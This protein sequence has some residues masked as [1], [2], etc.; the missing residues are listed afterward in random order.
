MLTKIIS[1]GQTGDDR[2]A[3][4]VALNLGLPHGGWVPRGRRAED[5]EIPTRYQLKEM[6]TN[7]YPARTEANVVDSDGTL[8]LTHGSLKGGSKLTREY[9]DTFAK[10]YLHLDLNE[11]LGDKALYTLVN[12]L[13]DKDIRVLNV[14]GTR[15]SEDPLIYDKVFEIL[16]NA[17]L[18]LNVR[19]QQRR[20]CDRPKSIDEAV[21]R[22][23]ASLSFKDRTKLSHLDAEDLMTYQPE[24][25]IRLRDE[26]GLWD[27][28]GAL[29][30]SCRSDAADP[31]LHQD[32][33][34]LIIIEKLW[35]HLKQTHKLRVVK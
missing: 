11:I 32:E 15:A 1:G 12:W 6:P 14:A 7:S 23:N 22:L 16:N 4:D 34:A 20:L 19:F 35:Q 2:A 29:L 3:L 21:E 24:L 30:T 27:E 18:L 10:P 13:T 31:H 9:A 8:I 25:L 26:F 5:G 17:L 28:N 33:A